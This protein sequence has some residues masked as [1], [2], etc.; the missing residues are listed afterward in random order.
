MSEM[1]DAGMRAGAIG[2][3]TGLIYPPGTFAET[4]EII[5]LAK[6][7]ARH[8]GIYT[9]HIRN[10]GDGV[11]EAL[12]EAV[13]IGE[14]SGAPVQISHHKTSG[15][16]AEGRT[17]ETLAYIDGERARGLDVTMDVYPYTASSSSLAAMYRIGRG[18][19]FEVVPSIIASVKYNKERYEGRYVSEIAEELDL[20]VVEAVERILREE[21]NSASVIMFVMH[22]DDVQRVVAHPQS[23]AGSDGL[24][25]EGKP[26]PR[27]YGTM[28]RM[29]QQFVREQPVLSL[30]EAVRKMTS[31]PAA[32]HRVH[33]RGELREGWFADVVVFDPETIED[34]ATY[35][36]P[37]QYPRGIDHVVVNGAVAV[38]GGTQT[39]ARAGRMLR[40]QT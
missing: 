14:E 31:L 12:R 2:L 3:S 15:G 10:E 20:P 5:E 40:R 9:S 33:E 37:R 16:G 6:V 27:L 26:H 24:P 8:G 28:A 13:R 30:E 34:I 18:R 7:A 22:E 4:P 11:M 36:E 35:A 1:L 17:A 19:A 25:T 38:R 32:K 23:M 29:L 39:D 21:D